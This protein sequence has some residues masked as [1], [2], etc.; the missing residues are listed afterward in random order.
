VSILA[1]ESLSMPITYIILGVTVVVSMMAF[2]NADLMGKLI[3]N[4]YMIDKRQQYYRFVTS[5]FI[6]GDHMH[7]IM[8]M[9]S[10]YFFGLAIEVTFNEH[11]GSMGDIYFVLLY[12]LAIVVSDMT[13]FFKN[14]HNPGYNSLGAS[15]GVSAVI[16][17]F[18]IFTPLANLYLYLAIP[19]KG[20]IF[21]ALYLIYSYYSSKR[22]Y[23]NIN[24]DAHLWGALFGVVFC[25]II[26]PQCIPNF[27]EQI[28][29]WTPFG[30]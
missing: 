21:G 16:F 14:R 18:I 15:G 28:S 10:L 13:T 2:N 19:I 12:L 17:A 22:S 30:D 27:I 20:F 6:H 5:G 11:F 24:H 4:P 29:Q 23:D 7:L 8:N 1:L 3:M 25:V 26:E 9:I